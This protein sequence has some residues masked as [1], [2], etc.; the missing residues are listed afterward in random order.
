MGEDIRRQREV[1]FPSDKIGRSSPSKTRRRISRFRRFHRRIS[2]DAGTILRVIFS[3]LLSQNATFYRYTVK[4]VLTATSEQRPPVNND[5]P[6]SPAL[7][8]LL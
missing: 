5:Q 8:T 3:P 6:K 2:T 7:L 4:P 1:F